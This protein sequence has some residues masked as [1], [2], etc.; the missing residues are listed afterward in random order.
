MHCGRRRAAGGLM[1][2]RQRR[3]MSSSCRR[4]ASFG[5]GQVSDCREPAHAGHDAM[6]RVLD[7]LGRRETAES[8]VVRRDWSL[9]KRE[10]L[11]LLCAVC[12]ALTEF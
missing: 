6:R 10:T 4:V 2:V 11:T 7:H 8:F 12:C 9:G 3:C 1:F 5:C